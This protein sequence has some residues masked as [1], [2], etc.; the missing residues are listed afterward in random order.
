MHIDLDIDLDSI[1]IRDQKQKIKK[2]MTYINKRFKWVSSNWHPHR[3]RLNRS[4]LSSDTTTD[5]HTGTHTHTHTAH[6][7][8]HTHTHTYE[9]WRTH[10][11]WHWTRRTH[12]LTHRLTHWTACLLDR[13]TES[14]TIL[15]GGGL[16]WYLFWRKQETRR[17]LAD[18]RWQWVT[19]WTVGAW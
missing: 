17:R 16:F 4:D 15:Q 5:T 10:T 19:T 3:H 2:I 18:F 11:S 7:H 9:P 12:T 1:Y 8:T 6:T 13:K 14:G